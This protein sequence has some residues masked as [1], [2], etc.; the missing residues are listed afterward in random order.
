MRLIAR[1][2]ALVSVLTT[3]G[4]CREAPSD[5]VSMEKPLPISAFLEEANATLL[6]LA[7]AA[8]QASWVQ[9]TYMTPDTDAILARATEAYV[10]ASTDYA[11]RAATYSSSEGTVEERRQLTLLKNVLVVAAPADPKE[12]AELSQI[13]ADLKTTFATARWCPNGSSSSDCMARQDVAR[14]LATGTR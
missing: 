13:A 14:E 7:I 4:A 2:L 11:K 6:K 3:I 9:A 10:T 8:N 12:T 5:A 1:S